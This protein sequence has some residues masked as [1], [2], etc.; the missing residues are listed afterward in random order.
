[1]LADVLALTKSNYNACI[2]GDGESV[3]LS[4]ADAVGEILTSGPVAEA[5]LLFKLYV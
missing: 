3:T 4:F 1:M 2:C 5:P